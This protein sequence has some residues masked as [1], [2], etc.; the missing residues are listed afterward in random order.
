[1]DLSIIVPIY[2]SAEFLRECLDSICNQTYSKWRCILVNDGST[3][4]SQEII[5]EYCKNDERFSCMIK[6]NEG[7]CA[8]ARYYPMDKIDS[9][10]IISVDSDDVI[11]PEFVEKL[12]KKQSE[13]SADYVS[14]TLVFCKYGV[15]GEVWRLPNREFNIEQVLSGKECCALTIGGWKIGGGGLLK[16]EFFL[17]SP[18]GPYINSDEINTRLRM[19]SANK[20]AFADAKYYYRANVGSSI[21]ISSKMFERTLVDMQLEQFVYDNFPEREDKINALAWQRLFN[22]IYLTADYNIHKS[23]FTKEE[24]EKAYKILLQSYKSMNR[25][26]ARKAAPIQSLMLTHS[27]TLFSMLATLYV[28]YKRSHGGKFY[29][30]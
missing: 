30:R 25:K 14:N 12:V 8:K 21:S 11:E 5:D 3:D 17:S 18:P 16:R 15:S 20:V 22:L 26:T 19:L 23:E 24:Q 28:K 1:M 7:S 29:Y 2:N 10:W 13:T 4:N 9:E 27:F 6:N